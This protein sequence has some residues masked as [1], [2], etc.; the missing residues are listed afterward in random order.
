MSPVVVPP[1]E[2]LLPLSSWLP[3]EY[4]STADLAEM[5]IPTAAGQDRLENAG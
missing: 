2:M 4:L 3:N 1:S 5:S